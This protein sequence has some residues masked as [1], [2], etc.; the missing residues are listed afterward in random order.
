MYGVDSIRVTVVDSEGLS[1]SRTFVLIV[2]PVNDTP[3]L[4]NPVDDYAVNASYELTIELGQT[5]TDIDGDKLSV[6]V[7]KQDGS[8]IP[9]WATIVETS[10][11]CQP[12]IADTGCV[13]FVIKATDPNGATVSE[14]FEVCVKGYPTAIGDF[15]AD[16]IETKMYPNPTKGFVTRL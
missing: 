6:E 4:V 5:F 14:P 11:V 13:M 12:M 8:D 7:T 2:N 3:I 15:S 16:F 9:T 1:H 10:M